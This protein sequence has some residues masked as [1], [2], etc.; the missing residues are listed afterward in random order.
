MLDL[1]AVDPGIRGCGVAL[2][3]EGRLSRGLEDMRL[4]AAAYV[5]NPLPRGDDPV[6]Q[7]A[8]AYAARDWV[9]RHT[10]IDDATV[11]RVVVE[12]PQVYQGSKQKGDP[13]DLLTLA[14]VD[15]AIAASIPA[16]RNV[17]RY[18]P[19]EWKG[20]VNA[21]VMLERILARL[22]PEE[23]ARLEACPASLRHNM[24][25]AIGIGLKALGRLEPRRVISRGA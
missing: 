12:W 1:L 4:A 5:R 7:L 17:S 13:R 24:I 15:M 6:E 18:L 20:Q 19:R 25:D 16:R 10:G 11:D 3:R 23:M 21:D 9:R 2:F 22:E 14:G 8:M